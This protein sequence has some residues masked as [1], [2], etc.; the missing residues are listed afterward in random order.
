MLIGDVV[1]AG[2]ERSCAA[3][4]DGTV[5]RSQV[6]EAVSSSV[7]DAGFYEPYTV[8]QYNETVAKVLSHRKLRL[9]PLLVFSLVGGALFPGGTTILNYLDVV[10]LALK[11]TWFVPFLLLVFYFWSF[12]S[13][14]PEDLVLRVSNLVSRRAEFVGQSVI[15]T[16]VTRGPNIDSVIRSVSSVLYWTAQVSRVHGLDV[17]YEAWIVTEEDAYSKWREDYDALAHQ[18]AR[19]LVIPRDFQTENRTQFKARALEYAA[20]SRR[21]MGFNT[22]KHWVY[23]QDEETVVGEDTVFGNLDF[24][25]DSKG[26]K[27]LGVGVI[28]YPQGWQNNVPSSE[29]LARAPLYDFLY[30]HSLKGGSNTAA[31]YHG[32]HLLIRAD[33]EDKIGWDFG[34]NTLTEDGIFVTRA[35]QNAMAIGILR[36]FAY[37]QPP[38]ST[39]E[40]LKQRRR[41]IRGGLNVIGRREVRLVDKL[42]VIAG[43]LVWFSALPALI[44]FAATLLALN[45]GQF[46]GVGFL[47]GFLCYGA[48]DIYYTGFELNRPYL[49]TPP[50]GLLAKLRLLLNGVL[51]LVVDSFSPW[52]ALL[53]RTSEYEVI[54]K[55]FRDSSA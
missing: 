50:K 1:I 2:W 3:L 27:T 51:G 43:L 44:G 18:G 49:V 29:E 19:V 35:T 21:R 4:E 41:W 23:H 52:Y 11:L 46:L 39:R 47:V 7:T 28:L 54:R 8:V 12:I 33:V 17:S 31:G 5:K 36:G 20:E 16:T 13:I 38:L 14:G 53:M 15:Y 30:L 22:P 55:G 32:S 25:L 24:I 10:L 45:R 34:P 26:K 42:P 48:F 6:G 37:E 40:L 9:I